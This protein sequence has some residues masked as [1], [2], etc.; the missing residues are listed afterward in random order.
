MTRAHQIE[1]AL[2]RALEARG[3]EIVH[4]QHGERCLAVLHIHEGGDLVERELLSLWELA[5]DM[6]RDLS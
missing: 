6:E 3:E 2:V 5:R 1:E 4:G